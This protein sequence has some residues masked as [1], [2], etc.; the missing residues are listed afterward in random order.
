MLEGFTELLS[1]I[2]ALPSDFARVEE[3]FATIRTR[4]PRRVPGRGPAGR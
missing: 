1:L 3:R 2:S 4:D